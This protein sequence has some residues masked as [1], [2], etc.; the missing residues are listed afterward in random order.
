MCSA[1]TVLGEHCFIQCHEA[2]LPRSCTSPCLKNWNWLIKKTIKVEKNQQVKLRIY[3][4]DML[5]SQNHIVK[6]YHVFQLVLPWMQGLPDTLRQQD[7]VS[8]SLLSKCY[9][10][11]CDNHH[12][13]ALIL[14]HGH[15]AV[16]NEDNIHTCCQGKTEFYCCLHKERCK[17]CS[18]IEARRPR[19]SPHSSR[20][21]TALPSFT[22]I[23]FACFNSLRWA[24]DFPWGRGWM[25]AVQ[26]QNAKRLYI[27]ICMQKT[28]KWYEQ[29]IVVVLHQGMMICLHFNWENVL[30]QVGDTLGCPILDGKRERLTSLANM[31]QTLKTSWRGGGEK[32]KK[33]R[34]LI[35][36]S[37]RIMSKQ[38]GARTQTPTQ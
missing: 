15:L 38:S 17:T 32:K 20:V 36:F 12:L 26:K 7:L 29:R 1:G 14:Q 10:T 18:T 28:K 35:N 2:T 19:A 24:K 21:T 22:T 25:T 31:V 11:T 6:V 27:Y 37:F 13:P 9:S 3:Q 16:K 33:K 8:Q 30:L 23:R 5:N 4:R 34:L